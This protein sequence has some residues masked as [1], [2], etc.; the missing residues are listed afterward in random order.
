[1][2][3]FIF[4][5]TKVVCFRQKERGSDYNFVVTYYNFVVTGYNLSYLDKIIDASTL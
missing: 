3:I 2:I 1:M 5:I 4:L